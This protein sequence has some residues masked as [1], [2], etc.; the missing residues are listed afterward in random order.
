M[1][2]VLKPARR[3]PLPKDGAEPTSADDRLLVGHG[4][5]VLSYLFNNRN[6]P[7]EL[8]DLSH[9]DFLAPTQQTIFDGIVDTHAAGK[10][11]ELL[12]VTDHL[13][14]KGQ[15]E[16]VGGAHELTSISLEPCTPEI[17]RYALERLRAAKKERKAA[18]IGEQLAK[19]EMQPRQAIEQLE[20]LDASAQ[21]E[22]RIRFFC[23]TELRD[24]D[25]SGDS[26]VGEHHI[27]LGEVVVIA[28][29][30]G[31]GKSLAAT[32]L[33]VAGATSNPWF[34]MPVNKP[35]RTMIIQTENGRYRL[36]QEYTHLPCDQLDEWIR[37][38]EPP[39]FGLTLS[40]E[41]FQA[42]IRA[43]LGLFKPHCV[44]LDPWNAAARDDKQ[45]DYL[46]AFEKRRAMLPTGKDK[47]VLV[48]IAHTRKP[49]PKEV[50]TGGTSLMHILSGSYVLTSV[51][52]AIF[53]MLR[54]S[55]D[56]TDD[57]I[58]FCNPKNSNGPLRSRSAWTRK[59]G[60]FVPVKDFDWS[61]FD[62]PPES[63]KRVTFEHIQQLFAKS[64]Q[65]ELSDAA[66]RLSVIADIGERSAYNALSRDK[67]AQHLRRNGKNI[68]F[69]P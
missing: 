24:Y 29:E 37:V 30:P 12:S 35:F 10:P 60:L 57:S 21:R 13:R 53:V 16:Q 19:R 49:Q 15:L 48:V 31:V 34:G 1:S 9:D 25:G 39:P 32:A 5:T 20:K 17:V 6:A 33:A 50:R 52:R 58:V 22:P 64:G 51:P 59:A 41:E 36:Q 54:G 26:L 23:P 65:F 62:R 28:G 11:V 63:R 61:D 14:D 7:Q 2:R 68:R 18:M 46:E 69:V 42:D 66:K 40:N 38:S 43:A 56:E 3:K 44:V 4:K 67:F 8:F 27:P 55:D 47:P 45:R